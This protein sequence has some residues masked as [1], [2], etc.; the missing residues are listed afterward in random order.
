MRTK[1][2]KY[3]LTISKRICFAIMLSVVIPF[4]FEY[5]NLWAAE[6]NG[7]VFSLNKTIELALDYN[8]KRRISNNVL[9]SE[10]IIFLVK[11]Y[12]YKIQTQLEQLDTAVE[13]RG[14]FQKAVDKSEEA[15]EQGEGDISQSDIT[16]LKLGL[17]NTL[18]DI[19]SLKYAIQ[20]TGLDLGELI[21]KEIGPDIS[22]A[23][24]DII[25]APFTYN[26]FDVFLEI[27]NLPLKTIINDNQGIASGKVNNTILRQ[28]DD[29]DRLLLHKAF[30]VAKE[31]NDKVMLGKKNRRIS[32]GLLVAEV[33]NY[34]F[35]IGDP[36][37]LFEALIVYTR[38]LTGYLDTV[39]ML[40][41]AV[42]ELKKLTNVI[43]NKNKTVIR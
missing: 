41:V 9:K 31:A 24:T 43:D 37:E 34:D 6:K 25:P 3:L 36:Q 28:L 42:A 2:L 5:C 10:D 39:Y 27:K 18:N 4:Q 12:F 8:S 15:F 23:K 26:D 22:I 30:I 11:K 32:R 20:I 21:G 40:N 29:G 14:H 35:G 19:I 17:S 13:V 33:A 16:K 38:V 7:S 1:F